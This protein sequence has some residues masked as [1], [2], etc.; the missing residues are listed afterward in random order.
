MQK[1][2]LEGVKFGMEVDRKVW[3]TEAS[4][5]ASPGA[6]LTKRAAEAEHF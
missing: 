1:I 4:L 6:K 5:Q 2:S 3:K